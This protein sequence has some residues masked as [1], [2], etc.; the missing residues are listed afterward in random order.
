MVLWLSNVAVSS[1]KSLSKRKE[2]VS[3]TEIQVKTAL[4]AISGVHALLL[5]KDWNSSKI[6]SHIGILSAF[7]LAV[8]SVF[9]SLAG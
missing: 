5:L 1:F 7:S 6:Q 2:A 9:D 8:A 3:E 4:R